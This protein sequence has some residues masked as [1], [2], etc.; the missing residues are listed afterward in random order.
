VIEY[1]GVQ[2]HKQYYFP[3]YPSS[4]DQKAT[5]PDFRNTLFWNPEMKTSAD[6]ELII[7][8]YTSD[9]VNNYEIRV[10]GISA[11]GKAYTGHSYFQVV[12]ASSN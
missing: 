7:E 8:F 11:K 2:P 9:D 4:R 10:E 12:S 3:E 6:G 1:N 5:T